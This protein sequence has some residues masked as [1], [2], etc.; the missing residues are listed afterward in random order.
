MFLI[1]Y[2]FRLLKDIILFM[3]KIEEESFFKRFSRQDMHRDQL[4]KYDK[5][6]SRAMDQLDVRRL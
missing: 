3:K 2:V 5:M 1:Q 4:Q 6:L